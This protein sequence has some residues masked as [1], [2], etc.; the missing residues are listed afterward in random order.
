MKLFIG[1][2]WATQPRLQHRSFFGSSIGGCRAVTRE[3][4]ILPAGER[5][6]AEDRRFHD[7]SVS[8]CQTRPVMELWPAFSPQ[9]NYG[10]RNHQN[11][12]Q[13]ISRRGRRHARYRS[14]RRRTGKTATFGDVLLFAD[15][16]DIT[17]G[18][19]LVSGAKVTAEVVEQRKDKKVIAFKYQAAQRLPPHGRPSSQIDPR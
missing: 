10:L 18:N 19:P 13:A 9:R 12:W 6:L 14:S 17:H 16:K 8:G 3:A 1:N 15:G 5:A 7:S 2:S 4:S 11:R